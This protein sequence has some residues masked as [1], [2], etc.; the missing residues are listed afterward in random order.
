MRFEGKTSSEIA[1][2][3]AVNG[4]VQFWRSIRLA[5]EKEGEALKR[6]WLQPGRGDEKGRPVGL[7][8]QTLSRTKARVFSDYVGV[9]ASASIDVDTRPHGLGREGRD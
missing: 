4:W 5:R 6:E 7:L 2:V 9:H 8:V 1:G 3:E